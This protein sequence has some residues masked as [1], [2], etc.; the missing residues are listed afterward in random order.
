M[1]ELGLQICA[2]ISD[3]QLRMVAAT[4]AAGVFFRLVA[5]GVVF[6][7]VAADAVAADVSVHLLARDPLR[8]PRRETHSLLSNRR[9]QGALEKAVMAKVDRRHPH[10]PRTP[11]QMLD[12]GS[13]GQLPRQRLDA[14]VLGG[15]AAERL[16]AQD[17]VANRRVQD[18]EEK[19]DGASDK[20]GIEIW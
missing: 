5:A 20:S 7:L 12:A 10:L 19:D 17:D 15:A 11:S 18:A 4:A 14:A 8:G 16:R 1:S 6:R 2:Y 3:H 9:L 13:L